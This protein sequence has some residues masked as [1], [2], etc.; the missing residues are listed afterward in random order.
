MVKVRTFFMPK[1]DKQRFLYSLFSAEISTH[2]HWIVNCLGSLDDVLTSL[3]IRGVALLYLWKFHG[4]HIVLEIMCRSSTEQQLQQVGIWDKNLR[5]I[6]NLRTLKLKFCWI[7]VSCQT[8][9]FV[10]RSYYDTSCMRCYE[11]YE[12]YNYSFTILA[13][14]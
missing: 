3:Q 4:K 11:C 8:D 14:C 9:F 7:C 5:K 13:A 2:E 10:Q 12:F 1:G 6:L